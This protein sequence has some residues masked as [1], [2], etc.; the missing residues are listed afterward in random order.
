MRRDGGPDRM[1][2]GGSGLRGARRAA[3]RKPRPRRTGS[4]SAP[5]TSPIRAARTR[6]RR[7][8]CTP[9]SGRCGWAPTC[10]RSTSTRP[11][12][13]R[14]SSCTTAPSTAP[15]TAAA[16]VYE[17]TLAEIQALD[18]AHDLVPGLGTRAGARPPTTA[19][20]GSGPASAGRR[21]GFEPGDFRIPTL[22]EVMRAYPDVPINIEI[23]GAADTDVASF[24]RNAEH[25][26][27][28]LNRAG[29]H[30]RDHRRLVQRRRADHVPR[31]RAGDRAGARDRGRRGVQA[32]KRPAG[33][34][35]GRVPGADRVRGRP[36]HRPGLRPARP[37]RRLRGPRLD[38]RRRADDAPAAR[39]GRRR[40]S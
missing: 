9:T 3:R 39:L 17:M 27:A 37:R 31:A 29:A 38:D 25:L 28:L 23:K 13:A 34:R 20:A 21:V 16:R 11:P 40:E 32:R 26:A 7:T 36:G 2:R 22:D 1:L 12:T 15:P 10:S 4:R 5:S 30:R 19:S 14:S 6:R 33:P 24:I 18:A 35:D 8:R